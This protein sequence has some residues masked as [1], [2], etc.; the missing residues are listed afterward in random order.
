MNAAARDAVVAEHCRELKMPAIVREHAAIA[1]QARDGGWAYEDFLA[2]VLETEIHSRRGHAVEHRLRE[3]HFPEAK[4][5][6]QLDWNALKGIS[7]PKIAG[8]LHAP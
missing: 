4:T 6:D 5:L 2:Q 1:R 8:L 3:A 7:K